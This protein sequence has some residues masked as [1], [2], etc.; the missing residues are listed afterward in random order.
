MRNG[1]G[2]LIIEPGAFK[3]IIQSPKQVV[4]EQVSRNDE[5]CL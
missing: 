1:L 5:S 4:I 3:G 2:R